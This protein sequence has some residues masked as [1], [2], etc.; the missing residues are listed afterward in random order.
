MVYSSYDINCIKNLEEQIYINT[1]N[2]LSTIRQT[3]TLDYRLRSLAYHLLI[4]E[5]ATNAILDTNL[6]NT[7]QKYWTGELSYD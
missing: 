2:H 1:P 3:K 5:D 7:L 4:E 6:I